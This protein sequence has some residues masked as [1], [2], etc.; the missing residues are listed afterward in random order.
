[1]AQVVDGVLQLLPVDGFETYTH[2]YTSI[3]PQTLYLI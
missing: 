1:M 3:R 2:P